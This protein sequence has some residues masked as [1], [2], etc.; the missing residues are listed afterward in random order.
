M[1]IPVQCAHCQSKCNAPDSAAG[2]KVK[3]PKCGQVLS[4]PALRAAAQA[5]QASPPRPVAQAP[6]A[7]APARVAAT[8]PPA[9]KAA[10]KRL[11]LL[12]FDDL[13]VPGRLRKKIDK[14]LG[15]EPMVWMGRP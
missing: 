4:V 7:T 6:V 1:P 14:E 12:S 10:G 15:D 2:R 5:P 8:V 11:L 9:P 13:L 3:C